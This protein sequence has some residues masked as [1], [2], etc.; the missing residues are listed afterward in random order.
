M[1]NSADPDQLASEDLDIHCLLRQGISCSA[2]E[3]LMVV[4]E[5]CFATLRREITL[6]DRQLTS[7]SVVDLIQTDFI[8]ALYAEQ[9]NLLTFVILH[10]KRFVGTTYSQ[11]IWLV[12]CLLKRFAFSLLFVN[13]LESFDYGGITDERWGFM[14]HLECIPPVFNT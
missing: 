3:G 13:I 11:R 14:K 1:T 4:S 7:Y 12:K 10:A 6:A 2:R 9:E 5:N 8:L